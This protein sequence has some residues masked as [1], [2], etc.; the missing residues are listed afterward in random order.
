MDLSHS[1]KEDAPSSEA[2]RKGD[3]P[4][5]NPRG[6]PAPPKVRI[7]EDGGNKAATGSKGKKEHHNMVHQGTQSVATGGHGQPPPRAFR[8]DE[9]PTE[10]T[11]EDPQAPGPKGL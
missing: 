2:M 8:G 10:K 5:K 3:P 4:G 9:E 7:D 6:V 1:G 11:Q